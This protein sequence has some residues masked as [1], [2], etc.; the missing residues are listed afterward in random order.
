MSARLTSQAQRAEHFHSLHHGDRPLVILNAWDAGSARIFERAGATAIA[1]TSSGVAWTRAYP[2]GQKLPLDQLAAAVREMAAAVEIPLSVDLEAGFAARPEQVARNAEAMVE[3]GAVGINLED[4]AEAPEL[5]AEKIRAVREMATS[6][7]VPVFI[8]ARTDVFL[9]AIGDPATRPEAAL[10]RFELYQ[11]AGADGV[12]AIG[13]TQVPTI[14]RLARS[15]ALPLN[16]MIQHNSPPLAEL[17]EAGVRRIT[18]GGNAAAA[19]LSLVDR[20]ARTILE[21][22]NFALL[23]ENQPLIYP[24][25]NQ[26]FARRQRTD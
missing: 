16:V 21:A 7:A 14:A 18:I 15:C 13:L 20:I 2:D 23:F 12:F 25:L 11:S 10:R 8:N 17:T 19:A 22:G 26:M 4:G 5:L 6:R 1:T 24:A 9:H 3:A